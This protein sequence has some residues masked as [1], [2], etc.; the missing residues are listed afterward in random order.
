MRSAVICQSILRKGR[1]ST[2][3]TW[4]ILH[5]R[6]KFSVPV[7]ALPAG[8]KVQHVDAVDSLAVL[9]ALGAGEL[10]LHDGEEGE[11]GG[12]VLEADEARV[13]VDLRGERRDADERGGADDHERRDGLVEEAGVDVRRLLQDDDVAAGAF[14]CSDL[15]VG[16]VSGGGGDMCVGVG[17][18]LLVVVVVVD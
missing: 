9:L 3:R 8:Y 10:D 16:V 15:A 13:E 17:W 18:G 1:K 12:L 7:R 6:L 4:T 5:H 14:G 11:P 2:L